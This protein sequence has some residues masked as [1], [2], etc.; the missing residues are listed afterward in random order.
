MGRSDFWAGHGRADG[1]DVLRLA[2]AAKARPDQPAEPLGLGVRRPVPD[3][4]GR[5][6]QVKRR[7]GRQ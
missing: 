2:R 4:A 1:A 5:P 6:D 7:G 3:A